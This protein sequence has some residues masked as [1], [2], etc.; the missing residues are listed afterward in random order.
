MRNIQRLSRTFFL[1]AL[2]IGGLGRPG[3]VAAQAPTT[4]AYYVMDREAYSRTDDTRMVRTTYD[5]RNGPNLAAFPLQLGDWVGQDL[6]I[7]NLETFPTL[8]AD[9]IVY[10]GYTRDADNAMVMFSLVGGT[11]GQSF[12]HP[13]VCYGWAQWAT[14]DLGTTSVPV[15]GSDVVLR[16]VV[17][18][19]PAG[20]R[21]LD[22][23]FYLWPD[24]S[25]DWGKGATQ[26]RITGVAYDGD[27]KAIAWARDFASLLFADA[28]RP[29]TLGPVGPTGTDVL[30]APATAPAAPDAAPAAPDVA[31]ADAPDVAPADA[32]VITPASDD[33]PLIPLPGEPPAEPSDEAAE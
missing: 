27:E 31:P 16:E 5:L 26:V 4:D 12:H 25:R 11:K 18:V 2:A 3:S 1:L 17:G 29:A 20:P 32:P 22:L 8:D 9:N 10:R 30:P 28:Q 7:T 15:S 19:D 6:P 14:E 21:Q 33:Q 13:L 23:S 24:D